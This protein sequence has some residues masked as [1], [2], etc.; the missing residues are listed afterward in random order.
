MKIEGWVNTNI[1][2]HFNNTIGYFFLYFGKKKNGV[3]K[4]I[5]VIVRNEVFNFTT[6]LKKGDYVL[7]TGYIDINEYDNNREVV[8]MANKID[9]M[10][11]NNG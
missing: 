9:L 11:V 1:Y 8:L 3:F 5:K 7:V 4:S 6:T 2:Y 10:D